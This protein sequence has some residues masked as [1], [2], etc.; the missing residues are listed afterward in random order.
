MQDNLFLDT[1][2][3]LYA[4]CNKDQKK[5]SVAKKLVLQNASISTQVINETSVNLLKKLHF[6]EEEV[7]EFI[8]SCYKRYTIHHI[9]RQSI[10]QASK[11]RSRYKLS[12]YDSL[13]V[14]S[15]LS[16][17]CQTLYSEDMQHHLCVDDRLTIVNP[18][19]Q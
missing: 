2:I 8:E 4:L 15:A 14:S 16:L 18:F 9:D 3:L 5:Q 19:L 13:I 11:L 1:N 6:Q 10:L 17:Q 12:F 7:L